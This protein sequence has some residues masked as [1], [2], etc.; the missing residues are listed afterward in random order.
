[1]LSDAAVEPVL[2]GR[3]D[4]RRDARERQETVTDVPRWNHAVFL[5]QGPRA[6]AV[7]GR[8]HDRRD[9]VAGREVAAQRRE[10]NWKPGPA[11]N[12]DNLHERSPLRRPERVLP[13]LWPLP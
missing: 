8:G 11:A 4:L 12:G 10:H 9:S 7:V 3:R 6:P 5:A 2:Q 1:M 13:W